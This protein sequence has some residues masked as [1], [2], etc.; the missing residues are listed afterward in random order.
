M[1]K[2]RGCLTRRPPQ[3][4]GDTIEVNGVKMTHRSG[5]R[6]VDS[7][8]DVFLELVDQACF[9]DGKWYILRLCVED[10]EEKLRKSDKHRGVD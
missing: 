1:T 2:R 5:V 8:G 10:V 4:A 7:N 3:T 6:L 9:V